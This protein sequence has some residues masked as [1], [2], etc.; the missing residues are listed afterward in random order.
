MSKLYPM[1]VKIEM[2]ITDGEQRGSV[3]YDLPPE[4][5]PTDGDTE[6]AMA[7]VLDVIPDGFRVMTRHEHFMSRVMDK[8]GQSPRL[9]LPKMDAGDE[10]HNPDTANVFCEWGQEN[11]DED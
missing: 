9:S 5:V 4:R 7:E 10:W 2:A 6:K 11:F 3:T 1:T 8:F